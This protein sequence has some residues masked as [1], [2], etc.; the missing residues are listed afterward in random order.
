M[1]TEPSDADYFG[2]KVT[3]KLAGAGIN[4]RGFSAPV[5]GTQFVAYVAVDSLQFATR[6]IEVLE[7]G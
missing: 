3:Q 7:L 2:G 6:A 1:W 5:I 4:W